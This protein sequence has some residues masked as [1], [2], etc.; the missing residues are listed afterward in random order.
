MFLSAFIWSLI[1]ISKSPE[2]KE[3]NN[4][5]NEDGPPT[6]KRIIVVLIWVNRISIHNKNSFP[7]IIFGKEIFD[8]K[9]YLFNCNTFC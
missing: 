3:N 5:Y 2:D 9:G 6:A 8:N 4:D 1:I 7:N